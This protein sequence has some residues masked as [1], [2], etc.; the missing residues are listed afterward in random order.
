MGEKE[1]YCYWEKCYC[2][3]APPPWNM[4]SWIDDP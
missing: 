4:D 2:K 1:Q 3:Y